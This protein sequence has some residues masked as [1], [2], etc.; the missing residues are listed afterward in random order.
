MENTTCYKGVLF[1]GK[2]TCY[3]GVLHHIKTGIE[4]KIKGMN[5]IKD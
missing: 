1:H 4:L 5:M 2:T 3:K